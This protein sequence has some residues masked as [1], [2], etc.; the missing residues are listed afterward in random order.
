MTKELD[1]LWNTFINSTWQSLSVVPDTI[2]PINPTR[3]GK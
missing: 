3:S 2:K 1:T